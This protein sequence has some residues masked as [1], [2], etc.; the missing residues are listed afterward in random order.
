MGVQASPELG[1]AMDKFTYAY[2]YYPSIK[3]L[4]KIICVI[5]TII[6]IAD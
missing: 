6:A 3:E 1:T 4:L 2:E 5:S